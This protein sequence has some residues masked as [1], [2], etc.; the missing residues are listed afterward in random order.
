MVP[1]QASRP[2]RGF[3]RTLNLPDSPSARPAFLLVWTPSG[4]AACPPRLGSRF[5]GSP[6]GEKGRQRKGHFPAGMEHKLS[7]KKEGGEVLE[8]RACV[9][10]RINSPYWG[11][12]TESANTHHFPSRRRSRRLDLSVPAISWPDVASRTSATSRKDT[13]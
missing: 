6:R 13:A 4:A 11:K 10:G 5:R 3:F 7:E 8:K 12:G 9:L 2:R 1:P